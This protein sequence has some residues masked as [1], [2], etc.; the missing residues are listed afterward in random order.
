MFTL[1]FCPPAPPDP[2]LALELDPHATEN[3]GIAANTTPRKMRDFLEFIFV[4][5]EDSEVSTRLYGLLPDMIA[6]GPETEQKF[7]LAPYKT[8]KREESCAELG[9]KW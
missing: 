8:R 3:K 9:L 1:P 6:P 7:R 2:K 5:C 4:S